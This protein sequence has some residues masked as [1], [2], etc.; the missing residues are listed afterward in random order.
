[1]LAALFLRIKDT[2]FFAGMDCGHSQQVCQSEGKWWENYAGI[3]GQMYGR[4]ESSALT[5]KN[6]LMKDIQRQSS[7]FLPPAIFFQVQLNP[8]C[9]IS[10]KTF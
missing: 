2:A 6:R 9:E 8:F 3:M 7:A 5:D 4:H 10:I 1:M